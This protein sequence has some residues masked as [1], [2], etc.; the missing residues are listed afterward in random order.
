M[1]TK[2]A[3]AKASTRVLQ[4]YGIGHHADEVAMIFDAAS[5]FAISPAVKQEERKT[6]ATKL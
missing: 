5:S 6:A 2:A 4:F 3:A 1:A